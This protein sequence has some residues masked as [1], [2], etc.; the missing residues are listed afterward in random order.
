MQL[1]ALCPIDPLTPG[2]ACACHHCARELDLNLWRQQWL[3][4]AVADAPI[5]LDCHHDRREAAAREFQ[6]AEAMRTRRQDRHEYEVLRHEAD[7]R[8]EVTLA[9]A[10]A[11]LTLGW[12]LAGPLGS[13][14]GLGVGV[15]A[16]RFARQDPRWN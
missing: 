6:Q 12:M 9:V 1:D 13:L 10:M 16:G 11:G 14:V 8:E 3:H 5:C 2:P 7:V 15:V 4:D